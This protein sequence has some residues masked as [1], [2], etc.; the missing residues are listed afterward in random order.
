MV[1]K[2]VLRSCQKFKRMKRIKSTFSTS[3][4]KFSIETFQEEKL[5]LDQSVKFLSLSLSLSLPLPLSLYVSPFDDSILL[6]A[7]CKQS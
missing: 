3:D 2:I 7:H 4:F 5:I 6:Q 1:Y